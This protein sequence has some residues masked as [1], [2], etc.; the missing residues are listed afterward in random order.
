MKIRNFA[1]IALSFL[2]SCSAPE[3]DGIDMKV[4]NLL[5]QMTLTE[6]IGQLC[7][8]IG[9]NLYDDE[10]YK[11][12]IDTLPVGGFWAVQR[13]DPWSQKT[14]ETGPDALKSVEIFNEMQH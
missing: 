5:S 12:L 1:I 11:N 2:V 3:K 4:D 13:A 8:P 14:L 9:F 6:K 7:C 10:S